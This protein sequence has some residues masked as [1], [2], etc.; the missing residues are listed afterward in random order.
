MDEG[1]KKT[2]SCQDREET[3]V[4]EPLSFGCVGS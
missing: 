3:M 2:K 1:L 4:N